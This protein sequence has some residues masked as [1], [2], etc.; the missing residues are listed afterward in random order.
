MGTHR[1]HAG[2]TPEPEGVSSRLPPALPSVVPVNLGHT[3]GAHF[4]STPQFQVIGAQPG[5]DREGLHRHKE[6]ED[7]VAAL[8][9]EGRSL[10]T[11]AQERAPV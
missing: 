3:A 2:V 8:V 9:S 6:D 5:L 1:R 4:L 7:T 10:E 11:R